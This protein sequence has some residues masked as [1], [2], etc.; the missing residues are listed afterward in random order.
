MLGGK[1]TSKFFA[2][3]DFIVKKLKGDKWVF[4]D[5]KEIVEFYNDICLGE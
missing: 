5:I 4:E 2:D 1:N 3:C